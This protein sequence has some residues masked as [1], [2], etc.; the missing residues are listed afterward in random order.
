VVAAARSPLAFVRA[1]ALPSHDG[2]QTAVS[3]TVF[4]NLHMA[5]QRIIDHDFA[6]RL[7]HDERT[8]SHADEYTIEY[9]KSKR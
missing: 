7:T 1:G 3:T 5:C 6:T 8:L 9:D 4:V 2:E